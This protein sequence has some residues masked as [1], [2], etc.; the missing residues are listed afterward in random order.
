MCAPPCILIAVCLLIKLTVLQASFFVGIFPSL[1]AYHLLEKKSLPWKLGLGFFALF[2][3]GLSCMGF[4]FVDNHYKSLE[5]D[6]CMWSA[7]VGTG[8]SDF[9]ST[10][11]VSYLPDSN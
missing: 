3:C 9:N 1:I 11:L 4:V 2:C 10:D 6:G 7:S 5:G 8:P